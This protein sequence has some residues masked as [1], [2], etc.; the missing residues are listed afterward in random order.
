MANPDHRHG[1]TLVE[2]LTVIAIVGLL[3]AI[4]LP[5]V[6][7]S[8]ESARRLQCGNH[9]RQIGVALLNYHDTRGAFPSSVADRNGGSSMLHTWLVMILPYIE[10][11]SLYDVYDFDAGYN[12][13]VNR[14]VV[15]RAISTY[16]CPSADDSTIEGTGFGPC[17]YGGNSGTEPGENDGMMFPLSAVRIAEVRDGTSATLL[18]GELY[19]H[20]L[21]WARGSAAGV[22]GGGGGGADAGFARAVS[23]WWRCASPCAI[24]GINPPRTDCSNRCEQRFQFSS[25]HAGGAYFA[26]CDGHVSFLLDT[27]DPVALKALFTRDGG[28]F[29]RG[30]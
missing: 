28:D 3:V 15:E 9:L 4:L 18:V 19:H 24:P 17:N 23:R 25:A 11:T 16:V 30:E 20:N 2:L 6:Q 13:T 10:Q 22:G 29:A 14:S 5:A 7:A 26:F 12:S 1:F 21:G 27:M 8:R